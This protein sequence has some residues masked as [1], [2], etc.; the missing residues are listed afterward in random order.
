MRTSTR[1]I[2][3]NLWLNLKPQTTLSQEILLLATSLDLCTTSNFFSPASN[4]SLYS[5]SWALSLQSQLKMT[6]QLPPFSLQEPLTLKFWG[7]STPNWLTKIALKTWCGFRLNVTEEKTILGPRSSRDV[8]S[9]THANCSKHAS[10]VC[11]YWRNTM[12]K[13]RAKRLN[14]SLRWMGGSWNVKGSK[15]A[16]SVLQRKAV[17]KGKRKCVMKDSQGC[18][19]KEARVWLCN[20]PILQ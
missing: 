1:S 18:L 4:S 11:H 10:R 13:W 12:R 16:C 9:S 5:P 20:I 8:A 14:A 6:I 19:H 7:K 3:S 2:F 17:V 15:G